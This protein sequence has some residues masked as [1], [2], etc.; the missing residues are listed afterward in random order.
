TYHLREYRI[1]SAPSFR[2]VLQRLEEMAFQ[3]ASSAYA[4]LR[5]G[6]ALHDVWQAHRRLVEEK[7]VTL[8][9][10]QHLLAIESGLRSANPE[11]WRA[12][13]WRC[14]DLL[15]DLAA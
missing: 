12:V 1:F 13:L 3:F 15:H 4:T 5:Y 7:L 8:N 11:E 2:A 9:L 14:R 6:N 10:Q